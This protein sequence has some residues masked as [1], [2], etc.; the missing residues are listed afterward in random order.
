MKYETNYEASFEVQW[1]I[2]DYLKWAE[3]VNADEYSPMLEMNVDLNN[4]LLLCFEIWPKGYDADSAGYLSLFLGNASQTEEIAGHSYILFVIR[5]DGSRHVICSKEQ[6]CLNAGESLGRKK[7]ISF[8]D[9][10][11]LF[12]NKALT[13]ACEIKLSLSKKK[14]GVS[15]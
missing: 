1:T 7:A 8:P 12:E 15:A 10:E 6:F 3:N 11:R 5:G 4:K 2:D 13:I 14:C 9:L